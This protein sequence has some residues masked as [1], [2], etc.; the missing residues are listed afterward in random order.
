MVVAFAAGSS[1]SP[2][3]KN[4][5]HDARWVVLL[6]A[7]CIAGVMA[8]GRLRTDRSP[9][10]R[11]ALT[12]AACGG[13][14]LG[15]AVVSTAWSVAP[16]LT[17]ERAGSL[18][19]LFALAASI[20]VATAGDVAA[21]LRVLQGLAGGAIAVGVVGL[22]M[23]AVDYDVAVQQT[24]ATSPWRYRGF[25]ENP[26]T[27]SVLAAVSVP[28]IAGLALRTTGWRRLAWAA[29]ALLLLGSTVAAGSRGPLLAACVGMSVVFLLV[30]GEWRARLVGVAAAMLVLVGGTALRESTQP[31]QP[32][33]VS[34]VAPAPPPPPKQQATQTQ[35]SKKTGT[36][37]TNPSSKAGSP[38]RQSGKPGKSGGPGS[39]KTPNAGSKT[40]KTGKRKKPVTPPAP[41][42][43]E[44]I[45]AVGLPGAQ[46]EIGNPALSR[47]NVSS[48]GSGRV[49]AWLGALELVGDRPLLGY[50]FGTEQR[51]FVDRWYYFQGG[52]TENSY[53]GL[54]L[55]LGVLGLGLIVALGSVLLIRGLRRL[56]ALEGEERLIVG[57]LL[58]VLVAAAGIMLIQSYLYSVGNVATA[59]VWISLFLLG[60]AVFE[61]SPRRRALVPAVAKERDAVAA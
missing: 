37:K 45:H 25:T 20:L 17:F 30:L 38:K 44:P 50:G 46:D 34:A 56:P 33:F 59:T 51:V 53:L 22:V 42:P 31:G 60:A 26:N 57:T 36:P 55:Q 21:R 11:G 32:Q 10:P 41:V 40:G 23:L 35:P 61:P 49:A 39:H 29:G 2:R 16:K 14:F 9:P 5:G 52:T 15:L 1:S 12:I 48:A 28:M 3:V 47:H 7:G 8:L 18:A 24:A 19:L 43:L 13:A 58:G 6:G 4:V 54:L 27:I